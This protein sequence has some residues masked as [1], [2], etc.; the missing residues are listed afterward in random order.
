MMDDVSAREVVMDGMVAALE[1][2]GGGMTFEATSVTRLV[3][4]ADPVE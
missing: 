1:V 3:K 2:E 4:A